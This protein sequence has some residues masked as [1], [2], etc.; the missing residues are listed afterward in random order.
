[1]RMTDP[2]GRQLLVDALQWA[3]ANPDVLLAKRSKLDAPNLVAF[4]YI[5]DAL[6]KMLDGTGLKVGKFVH[7]RQNEFIKS[8]EWMYELVTKYKR[9]DLSGALLPEL[10]DADTF[11][12]PLTEARDATPAMQIVDVLLWLTKRLL[13]TGETGGVACRQLLAP[14]VVVGNVHQ[15]SHAQL[16]ESVKEHTVQAVSTRFSSKQERQAKKLVKKL[17]RQRQAAITGK[18]A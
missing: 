13:S 6:H 14:V 3:R 9:D 7:D 8:F 16:V 18:Q 12:C 1:M 10:G 2:R 5:I 4:S 11:D 15:F 17:E